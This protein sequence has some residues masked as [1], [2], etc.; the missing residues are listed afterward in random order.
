MSSQK[1]AV[2][3]STGQLG[4]DFVE[5]LRR[6][7][8]CEALSLSHQDCDCT[9][10]AQVTSVL[11]DFTPDAVINCAAYVRVDDCE[12]HALDAFGVNAIGSL[13][14]ARACAEISALCVFISTDYVFDG[15]KV[16]PYVESDAPRPINVYGA[17]KLAGEYLVEQTSSS[18]LIVRMASLFGKTGAR[19]KGGN[20]VETIIKKAKEGELLRVVDDVIMSPTYTSDASTGLML[21]LHERATGIF[22]MAN[23]GACTWYEFAKAIV[24]FTR[25]DAEVVPVSRDQFRTRAHR[26]RNS[27]L[28]SERASG[29]K[30]R[31]WSDALMAYLREKGHLPG[32]EVA[33]H[34]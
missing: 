10:A 32:R 13:N 3:G 22:H 14:V 9:N 8:E 17:S 24:D 16:G 31:P 27:A 11:R 18:W 23:D 34:S 30:L 1:I 20:F 15:S 33:K 5:A 25:I 4:T 26:P 28:R 7:G 29:C 21:L 12:D 2:I 6:D 19:G